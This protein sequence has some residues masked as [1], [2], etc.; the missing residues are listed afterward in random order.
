MYLKITLLD[1]A[2]QMP[3]VQNNQSLRD[4]LVQPQMPFNQNAENDTQQQQ[5]QDPGRVQILDNFVLR[6]A[7]QT[8]STSEQPNVS[9]RSMCSFCIPH[10]HSMPLPLPLS[11][12]FIH[13][14]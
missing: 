14:I 7:N 2:V 13:Y 3:A 11:D 6:P 5:L 1:G 9:V 8:P 12:S 10:F 4:L